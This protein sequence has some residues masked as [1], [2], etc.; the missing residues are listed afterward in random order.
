[1][2][3]GYLLLLPMLIAIGG[4]SENIEAQKSSIETGEIELPPE[5]TD[6]AAE[7]SK[8]EGTDLKLSSPV[9]LD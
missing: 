4:C 1:M 6:E 5:Q 9:G 8:E 7:A 3:T 2:K